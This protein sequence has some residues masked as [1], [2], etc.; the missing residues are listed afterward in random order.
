M[1]TGDNDY[2]PLNADLTKGL[3][4]ALKD[5]GYKAGEGYVMQ[6]KLLHIEAGHEWG[7]VLD[8]A[9]KQCKRAL[10]RGQGP[11]K[12]AKEV[13]RPNRDSPHKLKRTRSCSP[14]AWPGCSE[15]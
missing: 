7:D 12:K 13:L 14:F 1:L 9:Y 2:L 6:A 10:T 11:R 4:S 15:R 8:R 3:S 5:G